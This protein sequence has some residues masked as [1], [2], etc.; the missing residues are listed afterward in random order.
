VLDCYNM[1]M[2]D[3]DPKYHFT[4]KINRNFSPE[5]VNKEL[6]N[7]ILE[8]LF[9][10]AYTKGDGDFEK[11]DYFLEKIAIGICQGG[12]DKEMMTMLGDTNCGKGVFTSALKYAFDEFVT[13]FNTSVLIQGANAN[14]EDA[15]K[16]RFLIKC[17]DSRIMIGNEIPI[18]S[19]ET[20]N[21]YG[22]KQKKDKPMNIAMIKTLVS[23]GD[24]IEA[25]KMRE[26]E[27]TIVNKAFVV[28]LANDFPK[29][30]GDAGYID[31]QG[32]MYA[33]RSS[34]MED[35]FDESLYF[36]ADTNIKEWLK[37]DE[38]ANAFVELI[39]TYYNRYKNNRTP[40]PAW[41]M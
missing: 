33:D 41:V 10:T 3:F 5:N 13:S 26:N 15:S 28:M 38:V 37:E 25:R 35:T 14:L 7:E 31:R 9:T 23:G 22:N 11:R 16:W 19:E 30:I 4:K 6:S 36:K 21:K 34:T 20:T 17:H 1:K 32:F 39:C 8:K 18:E 2:V 27:V 12:V 40:K 29:T 24:S